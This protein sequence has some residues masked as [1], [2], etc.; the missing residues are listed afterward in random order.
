MRLSAKIA[1]IEL[2]GDEVRVAVVK[3][4]GR[5]PAVI[6]AQVARVRD[7]TPEVRRDSLVQAIGEAAGRLKTKPALYVLCVGCH[8]SIV[9]ALTIPFKGSRKVA[10][11]VAFE[12]EPFLAVPIED[13]VVDHCTIREVEGETEVLAVGVRTSL[14]TEQIE[15]IQEAGINVEGI[16]LDVAGLTSLWMRRRKSVAGLH[17]ILHV[18]ANAAILTITF[19]RSIAFFRPLAI[20]VSRMREEPQ[21]VAREVRNS[22]RAFSAN[23]RGDEAISELTVTG[24]DLAP[25]ERDEFEGGL[26]CA[27]HYESLVDDLKGTAALTA[28]PVD[29]IMPEEV[30]PGQVY[31]ESPAVAPDEWA[32]ILGAAFSSAGGGVSFELRKGILAPPNAMKNMVLHGAFS[33]ALLALAAIGFAAYCVLD[34]RSN[35]VEIERA[36]SEIWRIY[37]ETFPNSEIV[38]SGRLPTDMG[39]I[40][41]I[42]AMQ[43]AYE[44]EMATGTRL[45]VDLLT[46]PNFLEILKEVSTTLPG[47]TVQVTDIT[48]RDNRGQSQTLTIEGEV[49]EV[50][51]LNQAFE[52]LKQSTLMQVSEEPIRQ[53]IPGG[54]TAFT[55]TATI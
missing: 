49:D 41:S 30:E 38:Q 6:E 23:W 40:Q 35:Q 4:G 3:T 9:R 33:A 42:Q 32:A 11:A 24:I 21:A 50:A 5:H 12:L 47:D 22:L 52:E 18:R 25:A 51:A 39:G 48:I 17:A 10:A 28:V 27:V 16:T 37:S 55:I 7:T 43:D 1:A 36:G 46:R 34:Y 19:N 26:Q 15:L 54:K 44:K 31:S 8:H 20:P 45:P 2:N 29:T 53:T 13:L 14:L